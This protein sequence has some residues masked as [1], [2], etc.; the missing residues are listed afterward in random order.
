MK[1]K[2]L[3]IMLVLLSYTSFGCITCNKSVQ[4]GIYN[5]AFYPN[6]LTMLSAFLVLTLIIGVLTRIAT[7]RYN[8]RLAGNPNSMELASIPLVSAAAVLG[9]VIVDLQMVLFCIRFFNGMKC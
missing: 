9:I 7:K 5:S 6:L 4:E 3:P 1:K 2:I 8:I